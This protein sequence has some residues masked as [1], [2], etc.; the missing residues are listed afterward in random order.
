MLPQNSTANIEHLLTLVSPKVGVI[1][2]LSRPSKGAEEPTPPII[3][4]ATLAHFDFHRA[5]L[6]YRLGAGKGETELEAIGGAIGEALERYCSSQFHPK[7]ILKAPFTKLEPSAIHPA[8]CVLYSESQYSRNEFLYSRFDENV[9]LAWVHACE[10]PG[11]REVLVPASFIYLNYPHE[12]PEEFLCMATS[13]GLAAGPDLNSAILSGLYELIERDGFMITWLNKL[14][15]PRVDFS[16]LKGLPQHIYAHYH[17]FGIETYVF[18]VTTDIPVYV[19]MGIAVNWS[20]H[21]PAAV[22]GLGCSLDPRA[23]LRK[24]LLES[25]RYVRGKQ[26]HI[27]ESPHRNSCALSRTCVVWRITVRSFPC[28]N[29]W[30]SSPSS[31]RALAPNTSRS[32]RICHMVTSAL[33]LT[34]VSAFSHTWEAA[35]YI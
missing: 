17:R 14:A 8:D 13:N 7:A 21:G 35:S 33:I 24:A 5:E 26:S 31:L 6:I 18:N 10:L 30:V 4:Q 34:L 19:M 16:S 29:C 15:A 2:S 28:Q 1:R 27:S 11:E 25:V 12:R 23:A 9:D 32:S 20:R 22:V 3:Y